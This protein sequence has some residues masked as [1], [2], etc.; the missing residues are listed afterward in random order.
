[1]KT[2]QNVYKFCENLA[3][4]SINRANG[5]ATSVLKLTAPI[6]EPTLILNRQCDGDGGFS[7]A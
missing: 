7:F 5:R 2:S 4:D 6:V 1:M 3:P